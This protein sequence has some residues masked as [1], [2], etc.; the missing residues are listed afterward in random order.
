[1]IYAAHRLL[2]VAHGLVQT[3]LTAL[4]VFFNSMG[5]SI[6]ASKSEVMLF[7]RKHQRPSLSI[8]IGSH[9]LPQAKT[10][11]YLGVYFDEGM[12]WT[13]HANYIRK[14]CLQRLNL[15]RSIAGVSWGAHPSCM[16]IL[17]KGLVGSVLEYGSIC[18]SGMS[19]TNFLKL[20]RLQYRGIRIS[21]GLMQSTPNNSLGVLSGIPALEIRLLYLNCRF[22]INCFKKP[23]HPLKQRLETLHR[24]NPTKCLS[25]YQETS[26][27]NISWEQGYPRYSF[28]ALLDI[29][30]VNSHMMATL[31]N[32][33]PA[34]YS[35]VAR[36][37][38]QAGAEQF[39]KS[40]ILFTD[41]S[42]IDGSG[43]FAVYHSE[44]CK[45][46]FHLKSPTS[47]FTA[48]LIAI[49]TALAHISFEQ[50]G[51][52][53]I[54]TDSLSSIRAMQSQKISYHTHPGIYECKQK[55]FEL[56][57]SGREV[58]LM[59]VPSHVGIDGNELADTEAKQGA[60]GSLE[61]GSQPIACD[62]LPLAKALM[63]RKWQL[64]W[65][66]NDTGRFTHSI[67]P[68]VRL[69]PW[70]EDIKSDRSTITTISRIMSGHCGVKAHLGRFGIVDDAICVCREDYET[71]DHIMWKCPRF[72]VQRP[73][74]LIDLNSEGIFG[75][76]S[77]RDLCGQSKWRALEKC[78][79]FL[80]ECGMRI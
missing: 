71:V 24:L 57:I 35:L 10:F 73:R 19:K 15:I 67:I 51:R 43:G 27:Y 75:E 65:D 77:I 21:L 66:N 48:E 28:D 9:T 2:S 23:N 54:A 63:K 34:L 69:R 37:E 39:E 8:I 4:V 74:L 22:L 30:N 17:Y 29:P 58:T 33:S 25:G 42:L 32:V 78:V 61:S 6:S 36:N 20:E 59:W 5:L 49:Y 3:A 45:I 53:L 47:V 13:S 50:P 41:G 46:S 16:L 31:A 64:K 56:K 80:K 18:Y 7:S 72:E 68:N 38:F 12:R 79:N 14:R 55:I 52:F 60:L 44:N 70:F 62:H 76:S 26:N 11:K 40:K 1:V